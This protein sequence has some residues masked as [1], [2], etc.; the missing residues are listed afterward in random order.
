MEQ[1]SCGRKEYKAFGEQ[2]VLY[3]E[4]SKLWGDLRVKTVEG[5]REAHIPLGRALRDSQSPLLSH[6]LH[7]LEA[8]CLV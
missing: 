2:R 1:R 4:G 7:C 8:V 3:A 6:S 5:P